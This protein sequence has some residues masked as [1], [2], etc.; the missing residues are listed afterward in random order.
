M[1]KKIKIATRHIELP[2]P[3]FVHAMAEIKAQTPRGAAIAGTALLDLLL[4]TA[5]EVAFAFKIIG[6]GAYLDLC[7]LRDIRNAFAHSAEAFDFE[8]PDIAEK[9]KALWYPHHVRYEKWPE[10]ETSR[11]TYTL[12]VML[13][14]D[15]LTEYVPPTPGQIPRPS[16]FMQLGPPWPLPASRK[17]QKIRPS[18]GGPAR[19][20][21][22]DQ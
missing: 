14:A 7:I 18:R 11:D 17:K 3:Y 15:G 19:N 12:A 10:T 8:R 13:L 1:S 2:K 5:I 4:R 9:C 16:T 20:K 22:T 6:S 21:K